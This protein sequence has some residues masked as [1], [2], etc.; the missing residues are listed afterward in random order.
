MEGQKIHISVYK[1]FRI[2]SEYIPRAPPPRSWSWGSAIAAQGEGIV[3]E[4]DGF[5]LIST[6]LQGTI[7]IN[8]ITITIIQ[9]QK[10]SFR[11]IYFIFNLF[12]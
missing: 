8:I 7:F 4:E 10:L 9:V 12:E 3:T 6:L 2:D 11:F 5:A 1:Y